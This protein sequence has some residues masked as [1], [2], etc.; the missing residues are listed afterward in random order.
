[1]SMTDE[2]GNPGAFAV[3]SSPQPMPD[4]TLHSTPRKP[5]WKRR[6]TLVFALI[7]LISA[8]IVLPPLV[9]ISRYQRQITAVMSRS[10][11]RPVHLSGVELRLL[12][13]PG[14]VLHDL[15]VSED[16]IFGAEPILSAS[17]VVAAIRI[18]SLWQGRL[19]VNRISVDDASLNLVRSPQ[20]QWNLQS[21]MMGG[22][23]DGK[24]G[25]PES[26][27]PAAAPKPSV[28]ARRPVP[29]PYLEATNS[30]VN[31]KNGVEKSPFSIVNTELSLWQD[32]PG[33]W[34]LR[35]RGQPA[36]TDM[37]ISSGDT[38]EVHVEATLNAATPAREM[39]EMPFKL[40]VAWRDA[41][42]GQLS[43]LLLGSDAGWRGDLTA[44][45]EVQG[46]PDAA[47]TKAR[48]RATG[49]RREEFA[50]ETPLDFD[51]N[52]SF[53]YQ[54]A[55]NAVHD[56]GC[57]TAIGD[58]LLHLKADL[59]GV[60]GKPEAM[61]EVKQLPLQ[62]GLDLLRTVRSGFAQGITAR[63]TAN[64]SLSLTTALP[65]APKTGAHRAAQ[66]QKA[67]KH[68]GG[69]DNKAELNLQGSLIVEG[70]ELRGGALKQPIRLPRMTWTPALI[71][72]PVS[73]PVSGP[74]SSAT[75]AIP[76]TTGLSSRFTVSLGSAASVEPSAS[77][78]VSPKSAATPSPKNSQA[79]THPSQ[80]FSRPHEITVHLGL[81]ADG[82]DAGFGGSAGIA[83][84]RDIAYAF[85]APHLDAADNLAAG[86]ADID[87]TAAGPW[88][89]SGDQLSLEAVSSSISPRIPASTIASASSAAP[90]RVP[91]PDQRP[92][93]G[94]AQGPVQSKSLQG[95][96]PALVPGS[97][98]LAG[99]LQIHHA[100]WK[101][102]Y[103]AQPVEFPLGTIAITDGAIA[104]TSGFSYGILN[105][106][107]I[108]NAALAC[109]TSTCQPQIHLRLGAVD[110]G[111]IQTA[112]LGIPE[113]KTLLSPLMDRMRTS[114]KQKWPAATVDIQAES[115]TLGPTTVSNPAIR[116]K[117]DGSEI[118]LESWEGA[119]L[120]GTAK[121]QGRFSW[122]GDGPK[123]AVEG[124]FT[125]LSAAS[126]GA[127]LQG[128]A[129]AEALQTWSGG[130]LSGHGSIELSGMTDKQLAASAS[131]SVHFS[132]P[133]GSIPAQ[134][135]IPIKAAI[136]AKTPDTPDAST[137]AT[138]AAPRAEVHF[139]DWSGTVTI[140]NGG[141]QLGENAMRQ[142][143]RIASITGVI[144]FGSP[145]K[146]AVASPIG[147]SNPS[148]AAA[149]P[150]VQ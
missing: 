74:V 103:L 107:V 123:Y 54:H 6:V 4:E 137:P 96:V 14:F 97:G 147:K 21:V 15:S 31:L 116:L 131:G 48:L 80:A 149:S 68:R 50:P 47:Q 105:G 125:K 52:C 66:S 86:V 122:T 106:T 62:A 71:S 134:T 57:D 81:T 95:S 136:P 19:T 70:G 139:D 23:L 28:F 26:A 37:E 128:P 16:P 38:G 115:L 64:G 24:Q 142:G 34:R 63:G 112:L 5:R 118:Q 17:T 33:I 30:R 129:E 59:P 27:N 114:D 133:H 109:V 138:P 148:R 65:P 79:K 36:R 150:A 93:Q 102:P 121:G 78:P 60:S 69:K 84:L 22:L 72:S 9:N 135:A 130:P 55:Q 120:G 117:T 8:A 91:G 29:F 41:Q 43:R 35:L 76:P 49:V 3:E 56:L 101:A 58:G 145:A 67:G 110:A 88:I 61:L 73:S 44:D 90:G 25:G 40:Q 82:Y 20:G 99:A 104:M 75:E 53:R 113:K 32:D 143:K 144:P 98:H 10:L 141:A 100:Q 94:P 132:W 85:G 126:L 108:V 89:A 111:A 12:P 1:M 39:R 77:T 140:H 11:G 119:L 13:R 83:E 87:F 127:V 92:V 18:S 2:A 146:L 7:A 42:L 124:D 51:A 45:M 46:T